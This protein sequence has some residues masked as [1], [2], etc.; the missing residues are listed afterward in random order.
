MKI[1]LS[2]NFLEKNS[3]KFFNF[4]RK[5]FMNEKEIIFKKKEKNIQKQKTKNEKEDKSKEKISKYLQEFYQHYAKRLTE[6]QKV[7]FSKLVIEFQSVFAKNSKEIRKY[8][9]I[10]HKI[11]TKKHRFIKQALRQLSYSFREE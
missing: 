5:M 2:T 3:I 4:F 7:K 11:N 9:I 1:I 6:Q 8:V 10:Q